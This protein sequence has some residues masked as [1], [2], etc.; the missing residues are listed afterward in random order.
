MSAA[1]G[2][3]GPSLR[4]VCA[5]LRNQG[6][7]RRPGPLRRFASHIPTVHVRVGVSWA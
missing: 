1:L 3:I 6:R 5:P 7:H 2:A 4:T